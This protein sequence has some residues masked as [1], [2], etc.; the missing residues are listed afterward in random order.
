MFIISVMIFAA[1][2]VSAGASKAMA[3]DSS[4]I[5]AVSKQAPQKELPVVYMTAEITP[6]S[7]VSIFN[8]MGR[9]LPGRVGVKI[10]TGEPGG[11]NFLAPALIKDLVKSLNGVIV[12]C[13]TAYGGKRSTT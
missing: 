11:H 10:S 1:V 13:N 3:A 7:L 4:E 2:N 12:E 5:A 8:K 9:K 6:E